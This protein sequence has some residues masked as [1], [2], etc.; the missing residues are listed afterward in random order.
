MMRIKY[1][2][3]VWPLLKLGIRT[4]PKKARSTRQEIDVR[5]IDPTRL[6]SKLKN[7]FES[8]TFKVYVRLDRP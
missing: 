1:R 5:N 2:I 7:T 8:G 4:D 6:A 3:T